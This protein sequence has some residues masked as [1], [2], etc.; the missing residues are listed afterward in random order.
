[1]SKSKVPM[2]QRCSDTKAAIQQKG[3]QNVSDQKQKA[4]YCS[5]RFWRIGPNTSP[6]FGES[7]FQLL[8]TQICLNAVDLVGQ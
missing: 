1:M 5:E 7:D 4:K 2:I 6:D 8:P 3:K